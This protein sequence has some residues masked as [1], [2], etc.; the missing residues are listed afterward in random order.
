[1]FQ[2]PED[3]FQV[4]ARHSVPLKV[5][6]VDCQGSAVT[7]SAAADVVVQAPN[8]P[9][10]EIPLTQQGSGLWTA[11]WTPA[12]GASGVSLLARVNK[13]LARHECTIG[14]GGA[15]RDCS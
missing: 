13:S 12:M 11:T 14:H 15:F 5:L 4:L 1:M 8:S 10:I 7:S 6:A 2:G 3:G 9:D